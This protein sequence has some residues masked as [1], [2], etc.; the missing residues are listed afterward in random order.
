[1]PAYRRI[2]LCVLAAVAFGVLARAVALGV[3]DA[4]PGVIRFRGH[5]P[6]G[7]SEGEFR[8]WEITRA[9]ID[10][11]HPDCSEV[12]VSI[13]LA[14]LDTGNSMRDRHL[15]GPDFLDVE[16]YPTATVKLDTVLVE[17]ADHFSARVQLELHGHTRDLVMHFFIADRAARRVTS[18]AVL[19]RT[20]F[21][22]GG[23][24]SFLNP[25]RVDDE[26]RII[27]EVFVPLP[28]SGAA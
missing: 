1:M 22:V 12:D 21:D 27:V 10:D 2:G 17:D 13:D 20:D 15:K 18:D 6:L 7:D 8:R 25:L 9:R 24:G 28:A 3:P 19:K 26:V 11:Q 14:S 16:H 23:L 5:L 4:A